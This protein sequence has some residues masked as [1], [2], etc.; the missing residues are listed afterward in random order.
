MPKFLSQDTQHR[1]RN[2]QD[3]VVIGPTDPVLYDEEAG[4]MIHVRFPDGETLD[5]FDDEIECDP[6]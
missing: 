2:G 4:P 1:H 3:L 5:V 6:S